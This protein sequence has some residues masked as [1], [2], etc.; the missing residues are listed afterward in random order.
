[1][2]VIKSLRAHQSKFK[3]MKTPKWEDCQK[4]TPKQA[5]AMVESLSTSNQPTGTPERRWKCPAC[6]KDDVLEFWASHCAL[7][8]CFLCINCGESFE[9]CDYCG[10]IDPGIKACFYCKMD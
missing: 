3:G 2:K 9:E 10:S 5:K 1:M 4:I 6:E 7:G 8:E